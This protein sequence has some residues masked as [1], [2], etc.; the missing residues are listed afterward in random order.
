MAGD[1]IF[2]TLVIGGGQTGLTVGWE[3]ARTGRTF[4][5]IDA[6]EHVGDPWRHRWDSLVLFTP[7]GM[8]ELPGMDFP[9]NPEH[10]VTK[11]ETADFLERYAREMGLPVLSSTRVERL[12]K[13]NGL[14]VAETT[15][16]T[17]RSHN[18]VVAMADH[19]KP[20]V[21]SFAKELDPS[22]T[23]LHSAHYKNPASLGPGPTLVVGMGNS[24]ADIGLELARS[25]EK[26]YI[27]G[28]P[29][30][31]VP[32]RIESWFGR[33]IG[34]KLIRF[35]ATRVMTSS[36]PIGRKARPKMMKHSQPVVRV[37]PKDLVAAGAERVARVTG[38]RDG[39][40]ELADGRVLDVENVLWCT[41]FE[42]GFD[43]IDLPVFDEEGKP[44]QDRGIVED[45]PGLYFCGL[46]FLHSMWSETVVAMPR[47]ARYVVE[48]LDSRPMST[49]QAST[50]IGVTG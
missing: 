7:A 27:S 31:V 28:E 26:T 8:F 3:V 20:R 43:W 14:F 38:V 24:G 39:C 2:D 12:S 21:P 34:V 37:K 1:Q 5:I 11:D 19:Q 45:E 44:K 6:S 49:Q 41:G 15:A 29:S 36:T 40:P 18:V 33:K 13:D 32:I 30:G 16:G 47:D 35:F 48:H 22:L 25:Q 23:Q 42:P 46:F 10:Y 50:G 9:G 17:F 4:V